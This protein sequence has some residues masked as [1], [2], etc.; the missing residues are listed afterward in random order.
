MKKLGILIA[1]IVL[2][3]GFVTVNA[4]ISSDPVQTASGGTGYT[5]SKMVIQAN[6]NEMYRSL[7]QDIQNRIQSAATA[8]E[9]IRMKPPLESQNYLSAERA[10]A[11]EFI[12]ATISQ[13]SLSEM[14][15]AQVD[16][17]RKEVN[18]QINERMNELK[19]R[20]AAHR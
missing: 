4:Q 13:M 20:R 14:L 9:N 17:A 1:G 12:K 11:E 15:K 2:A 3:C 16:D 5:E 7:P 19:A 8:I 10:R 6:Y 18:T